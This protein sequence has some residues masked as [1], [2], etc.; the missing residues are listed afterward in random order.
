MTTIVYRNHI[1]AA[2]SL[3]TDRDIKI[4]VTPEKIWRGSSGELIGMAGWFG[5]IVRFRDWY[6]K[7]CD[8]ENLPRLGKDSEVL[9]VK[10]DGHVLWYGQD[11]LPCKQIADYYAIGSGFQIA[12][13]ALAAGASARRAVEIACDLDAYTGRPVR[14]LRLRK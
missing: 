11:C 1:M 12:M 8:E 10:S 7:G 14:T 9:L 2:D 13:G 6:I 4:A 5:D 3:V